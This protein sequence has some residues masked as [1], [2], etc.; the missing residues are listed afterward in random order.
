MQRLGLT[1]GSEERFAIRLVGERFSGR[2]FSE[3]DRGRS[4]DPMAARS[5]GSV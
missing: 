1:V 4:I 2:T 5:G 3:L